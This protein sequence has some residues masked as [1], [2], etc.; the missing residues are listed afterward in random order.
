MLICIV[1]AAIAS[2]HHVETA[3]LIDTNILNVLKTFN[4]LN[5][6]NF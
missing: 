5:K 2:L 4:V 6:L 1:L 3:I